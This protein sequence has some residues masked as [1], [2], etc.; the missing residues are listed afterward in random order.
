MTSKLA[1]Q[2]PVSS[3]HPGTYASMTHPCFGA[4]GV[5]HVGKKG[6]QI[7]CFSWGDQLVGSYGEEGG[8]VMIQ[9]G[10]PTR[11]G[12]YLLATNR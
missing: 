3:D 4:N 12:F 5:S 9:A 1:C 7:K 8:Q 10:R 6:G 2:L 11:K